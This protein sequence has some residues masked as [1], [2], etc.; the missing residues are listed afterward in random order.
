MNN[1]RKY[2]LTFYQILPTNCMGMYGGSVQRI[3][4]RISG[5][6]HNDHFETPFT[7]VYFA[8]VFRLVT[9]HSCVKQP[10]H[11]HATGVIFNVICQ[12]VNC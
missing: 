11:T 3:C 9:Q 7:L 1:L 6:K 12:R 10:K 4:M 2:A 8:A 5:L